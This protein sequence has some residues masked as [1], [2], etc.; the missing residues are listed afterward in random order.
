M[1]NLIQGF[2]GVGVAL[3]VAGRKLPVEVGRKP[4]QPGS[5][6]L[7]WGSDQPFSLGATMLPVWEPLGASPPGV[8]KFLCHFGFDLRGRS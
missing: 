3:G 8:W 2:D 1:L 5:W 4:L 6:S 7:E